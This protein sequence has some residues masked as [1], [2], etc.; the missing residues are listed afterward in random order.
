V[1]GVEDVRRAF[2]VRICV[3]DQLLRA[4][5]ICLHHLK[6]PRAPSEPPCRVSVCNSR[7]AELNT[8]KLGA[9]GLGGW[10]SSTAPAPDT[11]Q[12]ETYGMAWQDSA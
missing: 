9:G 6:F 7:Q 3:R 8:I 10:A 2:A 1:N 11:R 4:E 12:P 5:E